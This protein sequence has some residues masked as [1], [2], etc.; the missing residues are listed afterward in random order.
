MGGVY[1][2]VFSGGAGHVECMVVRPTGESL[3]L[4]GR[5]SCQ[6]SL[7]REFSVLCSFYNERMVFDMALYR[8]SPIL[9]QLC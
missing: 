4:T 6:T 7:K 9:C 8:L 5:S 3:Y 2:E 1:G